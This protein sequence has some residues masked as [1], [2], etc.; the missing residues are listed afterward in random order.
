MLEA[1]ESKDDGVLEKARD[2]GASYM[3]V[4]ISTHHW[5][6]KPG[7]K[8][9]VGSRKEKYVDQLGNPDSL[10]EKSRMILRSL[11]KWQLPTGYVESVHATSMR[12]RNPDNGNTITGEVGDEIGRGGR[13][14]WYFL[15]EAAF[16]ERAEKV[17]AGLL[18]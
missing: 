13:S 14:S 16:I 10:L 5:L 12:F 9:S 7:F 8:T 17:E 2:T 11:P 3:G 4:I 6:F 15:D 1:I 18:C